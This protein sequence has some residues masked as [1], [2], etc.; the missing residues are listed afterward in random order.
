MKRIMVLVLTMVLVAVVAQAQTP[1]PAAQEDLR[2]KY[3]EERIGRLNADF[4]L[5]QG[6]LNAVARRYPGFF[7]EK[8]M[9]RKELEAVLNAVARGIQAE[10]TP[11]AKELSELQKVAKPKEPAKK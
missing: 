9:A 6:D 10:V 8:G 11:L 7:G 1:A 2:A 5:F 3:I 4:Q